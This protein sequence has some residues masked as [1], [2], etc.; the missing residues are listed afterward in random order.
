MGA[1]VWAQTLPDVTMCVLE[2]PTKPSVPISQVN[3]PREG[4]P[5]AKVTQQ[6]RP[7]T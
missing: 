6:K 4:K 5:G 3:R 7:K 2:G 1:L